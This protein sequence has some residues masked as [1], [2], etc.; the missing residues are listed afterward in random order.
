MDSFLLVFFSFGF[1]LMLARP[2]LRYVSVDDFLMSIIKLNKSTEKNEFSNRI[3]AL[4]YRIII[5]ILLIRLHA[6]YSS[7]AQYFPHNIYKCCLN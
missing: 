5:G 3:R 2:P 4:T 7:Y 1:L 6:I